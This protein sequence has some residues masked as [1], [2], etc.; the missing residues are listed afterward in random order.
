MSTAS[1]IP[2]RAVIAL[3]IFV[4]TSRLPLHADEAVDGPALMQRV[5]DDIAWVGKL[6]SFHLM[7]RIEER[8]TP[9]G[10]ANELRDIKRQFPEI[11]QPDPLSFTELLPEIN[12]RLEMDFDARR[13]RWC[14]LAQDGLS[15][16]LSRDL[17]MWDGG[18]A[19]YHD[20][21]FHPVRDSVLFR[22]DT[23]LVTD[24]YWGWFAYPNRQPLVCWWNDNPEQREQLQRDYGEPSIFVL[25]DRVDFHG[26]D[27]HVLLEARH[28]YVNRYYIGVQDGR[29]H[30]LKIGVASYANIPN[31]AETNQRLLAEFLGKSVAA[32]PSEEAWKEMHQELEASPVNR[33]AAWGKRM[34]SEIGKRLIPVWEIR[35]SDFRELGEG[36]FLPFRETFVFYKF[37]KEDKKFVVT[38]QRTHFVRK[39]TL[40]QPLDDSLFDEP[41]AA[42][43]TVVDETAKQ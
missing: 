9:E 4:V 3:I 19:V 10:I 39:L 25:V 40:N 33:R 22:K 24:G 5:R 30:G 21:C 42:G 26:V 14:W 15:R 16:E 32:I 29:L 18:R 1:R 17:R 41:I 23:S 27:C 37:H 34:Y 38:N 28:S 13:I 2:L 43:A 8:R 31:F 35:Y 20:Q 7:A 36:H 12:I 6:E 11:E